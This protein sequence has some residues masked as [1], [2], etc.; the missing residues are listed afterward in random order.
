MT[1]FFQGTLVIPN[2]SSVLSEE[3]RWKFPNE[4]N[5]ENFLNDQGEIL[6]NESFMPFSVGERAR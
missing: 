4:F 6:K 5:P 2:L 3:G 1:L